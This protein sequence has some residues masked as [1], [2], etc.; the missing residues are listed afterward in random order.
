MLIGKLDA[1]SWV[2]TCAIF[3]DNSLTNR[4]VRVILYIMFVIYT[5]RVCV[6]KVS[7]RLNMPCSYFN[8]LDSDRGSQNAT[9]AYQ[10][11]I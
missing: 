1:I 3:F 2:S 9:Q 6:Y 7:R 10:K 5:Y 11:F 8:N 4:G